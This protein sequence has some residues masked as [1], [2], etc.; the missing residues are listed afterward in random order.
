MGANSTRY[1]HVSLLVASAEKSARFYRELFG[2]AELLRYELGAHGF[3]YHLAPEEGGSVLELIEDDR[4]RRAPTDSVH[5]GFSC[6]NLKEFLEAL[7][8]QEIAIEQGPLKVG[9]ETIVFIR[10]P[11]GYLIEI[12]DGL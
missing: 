7:D 8:R 11:D 5:L 4:R 6:A 1:H 2:Y 9:R 3:I 12:N 10:D